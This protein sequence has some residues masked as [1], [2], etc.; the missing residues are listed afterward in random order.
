[1]NS[2]SG[3]AILF[4]ALIGAVLLYFTWDTKVVMSIR[5]EVD[6]ENL[7]VNKKPSDCEFLTA[8]LGSKHCHYEKTVYKILIGR[9]GQT[10][11]P[12]TSDDG[13]TSWRWANPAPE[14]LKTWPSQTTTSY[15]QIS[16]TKVE[17]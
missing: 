10:G 8:P 4:L 5:Y 15:V 2:E 9:D 3:C 6:S 11:R 7:V 13:G 16:W 12:V 14:R 17:D 1:V